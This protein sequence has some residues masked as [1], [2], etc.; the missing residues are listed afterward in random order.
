MTGRSCLSC[1]DRADNPAFPVSHRNRLTTSH[2]AVLKART[3]RTDGRLFILVGRVRDQDAWREAFRSPD[4]T[5]SD[6]DTLPRIENGREGR[7][8]TCG[9]TLDRD[10]SGSSPA[11]WRCARWGWWRGWWWRPGRSRCTWTTTAPARAAAAAR[12]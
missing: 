10:P 1:P 4:R 9:L 11:G 7:R 5:R 2:L 3:A 6:V 12:P 8:H